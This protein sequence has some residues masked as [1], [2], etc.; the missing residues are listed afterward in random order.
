[1][2]TSIYIDRYLKNNCYLGANALTVR[3]RFFHV[4]NQQEYLIAGKFALHL[5]TM[6]WKTVNLASHTNRR[7]NKYIYV[8]RKIHTY[9]LNYLQPTNLLLKPTKR[10]ITDF[11]YSSC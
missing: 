3:L 6:N 10:N 1:M 5:C 7:H 11:H 9:K 4:A 8:L 2:Q